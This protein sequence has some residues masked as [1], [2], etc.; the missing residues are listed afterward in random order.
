MASL[1]QLKLPSAMKPAVAG[2]WYDS[3]D[4]EQ[5]PATPIL[6]VLQLKFVSEVNL[7]DVSQTVSV[8]W[9]KS[10]E[11]LSTIPGFQ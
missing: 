11:F 6:S 8:L 3:P 9:R 10:V 7:E 1:K 5:L 4:W 2:I